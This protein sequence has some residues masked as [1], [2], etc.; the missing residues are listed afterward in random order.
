MTQWFRAVLSIAIVVFLTSSAIRPAS[1][2]NPDPKCERTLAALGSGQVPVRIVCFGDS[3]TG[4]Y[5]HTGGRRAYAD[6]I[7]IAL[8]RH[9]PNATIQMLN[10]GI[11]GETTRGALKRMERDVLAHKP[12]LVT[13]MFGMNDMAGVPIDEYRR[14]LSEIVARC[15]SAET[16]VLLCTSNSVQTT[17]SRPV[18]KL[19][20]Y[21]QS[22]R[23]VAAQENTPVADC[24]QAFE[25]LRNTDA[26]EWS[27]LLSD[28]IH[29]NMDG[30]KLM[31]ETIVQ[32]IT[33][34]KSS[35]KDVPPPQPAIPRTL[36][37]LKKKEPIK[38]YAMAPFDTL[39]GPAVRSVVPDAKIEV[40][41]WNVEGKS[42][43]EIEQSAKVVRNRKPD[44]VI[45]AVPISSL[46]GAAF[47]RSFSWVLNHSLSFGHQEWDCI[48]V[49]PR[50]ANPAL[51]ADKES[52]DRLVTRLIRA[53]DLSAI[54]RL[55][56]DS[57]PAA[58][59][60]RSW[61]QTQIS[62][63]LPPPK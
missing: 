53:Q 62:M 23:E 29:P 38:V 9:Y 58:D 36:S 15:R 21:M 57:R 24:Y 26:S 13:V 5:Y 4:V 2:A 56:G 44:M 33:G 61:L 19:E 3:L 27:L 46:D 60:L 11:S 51:P 39:I 54:E 18:S 45:V 8:R 16:E 12:H 35:L 30:D 40:T 14:N 43:A 63:E 22:L 20:E 41:S 31:A 10:A 25:A 17:P 48:P 59:I 28:E 47:P 34:K 6:M 42:I 37:L 52:W 55:P 32:A 49:A 7:G 50:V 1:A